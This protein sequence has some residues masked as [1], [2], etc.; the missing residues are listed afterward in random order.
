MPF[1][2]PAPT[3]YAART[4]L[5]DFAMD[6]VLIVLGVAV[7]GLAPLALLAW[8]GR[9]VGRVQAAKAPE[10]AEPQRIPSTSAMS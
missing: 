6:L 5:E 9:L 3:R 1:A 10:P 4:G 7:A 8:V 2:W